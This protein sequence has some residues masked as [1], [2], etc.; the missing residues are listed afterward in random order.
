MISPAQPFWPCSY[1]CWVHTRISVLR[2]CNFSEEQHSISRFCCQV[3]GTV[4]QRRAE[5]SA[6]SSQSAVIQALMTARKDIPGIRGRLGARLICSQR[7]LL[8]LKFA[9]LKIGPSG[10]FIGS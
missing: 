1:P 6:Q 2:L 8:A 9:A 3:R 7:C 4:A 10:C 5:R